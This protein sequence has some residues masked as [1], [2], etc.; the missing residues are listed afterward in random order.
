M[1]ERLN[2]LPTF[3]CIDDGDSIN[4]WPESTASTYSEANQAGRARAEELVDVIRKTQS[5]SLLGHVMEAIAAKG[6]SGGMEVGFFH[7]LS[8]ELMNPHVIREFVTAPPE[9][10]FRL[11]R[12]V[13]HLAVVVDGEPA[14]EDIQRRRTAAA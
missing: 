11:G 3:T 13:R 6:S 2:A 12:K 7:A 5:P 10:Q 4:L 8:I 9:R 1:P 14:N